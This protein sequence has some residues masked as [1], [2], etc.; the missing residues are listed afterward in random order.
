MTL[1]RDFLCNNAGFFCLFVCFSGDLV[2][3]VL[4]MAFR[5]LA[6]VSTSCHKSVFFCRACLISSYVWRICALMR[7]FSLMMCLFVFFRLLSISHVCISFLLV[8]ICTLLFFQ[9]LQCKCCASF[10]IKCIEVL[11][12]F[13]FDS[14]AISSD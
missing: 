11:V 12:C 8:L 6:I 9:L 7:C 3:F 5:Y 4:V 1:R 10:S 13:V 14:I 2:V